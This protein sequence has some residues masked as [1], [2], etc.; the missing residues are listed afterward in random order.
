MKKPTIGDFDKQGHRGCRALMPE[1]TIPGMLTAIELGVST[2]ELDVVITKDKKVIV[3]HEPF[4][5]HEITTKPDGDYVTEREEK[6]LNI[7]EMTF[8]ETTRFD[9]GLKPHPRFPSQKKIKTFK[10]L[11]STLIDTVEKFCRDHHFN[12]PFYNIETKCNPQTDDIYHP[13]PEEFIDLLI[14]LLKGKR[15]LNRIIIQSFDIRTL[16]VINKNHPSVKTS[17]LIDEDNK[18]TLEH[19]LK[20]LGFTPSIYSPHHTLITKAVVDDCHQKGIKI[21]PWTVNERSHIVDL[22]DLGVDGIITDNPTLFNLD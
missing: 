4:F 5:N 1:N 13:A 20:M 19:N 11:L 7:Y 18:I 2:L 6:K 8:E 16:Q 21:I 17:L 12:P 9:V 22:K 3:S 15:V 14:D 10:P